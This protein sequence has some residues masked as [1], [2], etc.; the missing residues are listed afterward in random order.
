MTVSD[1]TKA[2]LR[3]RCPTPEE[4][5][6]L[7]DEIEALKQKLSDQFANQYRMADWVEMSRTYKRE[8]DELRAEVETLKARAERAERLR[9][10][11][12][13]AGLK[14]AGI[15]KDRIGTLE[16]ALRNVACCL[17]Q[18]R[19]DMN[20][21]AY[22]IEEH[23][24]RGQHWRDRALHR[25]KGLI[26]RVHGVQESVRRALANYSDAVAPTREDA[27]RQA[28]EPLLDALER[29]RDAVNALAHRSEAE[30]PSSN[31]EKATAPHNSGE[32]SAA[33]QDYRIIGVDP[34]KAGSD[35]VATYQSADEAQPDT[36]EDE[37][38]PDWVQHELDRATRQYRHNDDNSPNLFTP[39]QGF[40]IAYDP[41][42]IDP[43][44][45]QALRARQRVPEDI[46]SDL[47]QV[48]PAIRSMAPSQ[49]Q[50]QEDME[51]NGRRRGFMQAAEQAETMIDHATA[52]SEGGEK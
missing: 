38:L 32:S 25:A 47:R 5:D 17:E 51:L 36:G 24:S 46:R 37:A 20:C 40:V 9:R 49:R 13:E 27:V 10:E 21:W 48:A 16:T 45:R 3:R 23:G 15:D 29:A 14:R 12:A 50:A 52:R 11:D 34:A 33:E 1:K 44:I 7:L 19:G 31:R 2:E 39:A 26:H 41:A 8:R 28:A 35:R 4:V 18:L 22:D 30:Q 6:G 42:V 43:L